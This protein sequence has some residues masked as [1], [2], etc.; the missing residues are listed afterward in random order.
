MMNIQRISAV[1]L[2]ASVV[3]IVI[4]FLV[5]VPGFYQT[6]D[7]AERVRLVEK[8][9]TRWLVTI[10][11]NMVVSLLPA[12]GL[13]LYGI[14]LWRS[15]GTLLAVLGASLYALGAIA[16]VIHEYV[17]YTDLV[18]HFGGSYPDYHGIGNWF[19]LAGLFALGVS[20]LQ[21][22]LPNWLAYL[23]IGLSIVLGVIWLITPGFFFAIPFFAIALFL[24]ISIV[25]LRT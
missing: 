4:S 25:L 16:Y 15:N 22:G 7:I 19:V 24:V 2:V 20:F 21:I 10:F 14:H 1:L 9:R 23:S 11:I 5:G 13:V 18:G 3:I 8:F 17:R 6:Q 12:I